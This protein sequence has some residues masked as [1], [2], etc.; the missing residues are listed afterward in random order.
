MN[1]PT[2]FGPS[3]SNILTKYGRF[4]LFFMNFLTSAQGATSRSDGCPRPSMPIGA[5]RR[6]KMELLVTRTV[7]YSNSTGRGGVNSRP[8]YGTFPPAGLSQPHRLEA[9]RRRPRIK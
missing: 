8:I 2:D 7:A 1:S 4:A 3:H 6:N 9:G 5:A